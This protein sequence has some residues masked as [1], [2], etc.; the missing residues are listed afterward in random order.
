MARIEV[1]KGERTTVGPVGIVQMGAGGV[2]AGR[3]MQEAG[4]RIFEEG[5]KFLVAEE[6]KE[7]KR[8][9]QCRYRCKR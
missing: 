9:G 4:Q 1:L 5:F 8:S 2:R 6:T 3:Q 7:G